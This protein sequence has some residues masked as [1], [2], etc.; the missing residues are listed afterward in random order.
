MW[1][2]L[3]LRV[4]PDVVYQQLLSRY[5][6]AHRA[7]HTAQHLD[8][9]L[10]LFEDLRGAMQRPGE[11]ACALWYHDAV[12]EP[13]AG[14]NEARSADLAVDA[15]TNAGARPDQVSRIR[16]LIMDTTHT[17]EPAGTDGSLLVDIDLA[18]LGAAPERFA[19]YET[20]IRAEYSW[21]PG[22]VYRFERRRVLTGFLSRKPIY[23]SEPMRLRFEDRARENLQRAVGAGVE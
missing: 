16:S 2:L 8:E 7:Y 12:Y 15:L 14:D 20:Q 19:E 5:A 22:I 10:A 9:C 1:R 11:V 18:I 3:E 6:E 17:A 13:K 4:P 23:R 21:V